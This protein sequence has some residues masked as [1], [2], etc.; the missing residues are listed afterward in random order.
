MAV[1]LVVGVAGVVSV[2]GTQSN[3]KRTGRRSVLASSPISERST[4]NTTTS[5]GQPVPTTATLAAPA[6][7]GQVTAASRAAPRSSSVVTSGAPSPSASPASSAPSASSAA[8]STTVVAPTRSRPFVAVH[9][10]G[11]PNV[12]RNL[13]IVDPATGAAKLFNTAQAIFSL[14]WNPDAARAV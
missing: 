2:R 12:S 9:H 1:L 13:A 3:V 11:S 4:A 6:S 8:P 10:T 5:V 14:S 7:A